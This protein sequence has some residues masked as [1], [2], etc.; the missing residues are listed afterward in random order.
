MYYVHFNIWLVLRDSS[1]FQCFRFIS[2]SFFQRLILWCCYFL[3]IWKSKNFR[4]KPAYLPLN[5]KQAMIIDYK[6]RQSIWAKIDVIDY[7]IIKDLA[8]KDQIY[9]KITF[10]TNISASMYSKF[11]GSL[12]NKVFFFYFILHVPRFYL[13]RNIKNERT[14]WKI[15]ELPLG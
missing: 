13:L 9:C 14:F 3:L 15:P 4:F 2:K 10:I 8:E 5:C 6:L 1:S 11:S 7:Q 12:L